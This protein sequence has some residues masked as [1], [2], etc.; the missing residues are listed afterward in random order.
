MVRRRQLLIGLAS[1]VAAPVLAWA[2][3]PKM[4]LVAILT[5][6]P[7]VKVGAI[8]AF[9]EKLRELGWM[10]GVTI[11]LER[12]VPDLKAQDMSAR[13]TDLVNLEPDALVSV[14]TVY[15][16]ALAELTGRIPIV[17]IMHQIQSCRASATVCQSLAA[18]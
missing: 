16:Q 4:P 6:G 14:G 2:Q 17:F 10:D 11:R 13:A 7:S 3:R 18:I 5:D 1:T 15:T 12:R 9:Q 8:A